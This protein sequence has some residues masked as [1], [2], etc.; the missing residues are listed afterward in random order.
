[1]VTHEGYCRE[2]Q[3][4]L[5]E[6]QEAARRQF[7]NPR[8]RAKPCGHFVAVELYI[9]EVRSVIVGLSEDDHRWYVLH[10]PNPARPHRIATWGGPCRSLADVRREGDELYR[11]L[12]ADGAPVRS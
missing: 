8:L 1:M 3:R 4:L 5:E 7:G 11:H 6:G 9:D 10:T 12:S 2:L